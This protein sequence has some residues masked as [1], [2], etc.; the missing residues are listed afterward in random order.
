MEDQFEN[1]FNSNQKKALFRKIL[2]E[3]G[4][5]GILF[6]LAAGVFFLSSLN[7][8]TPLLM[9]SFLLFH[10]F[11]C[12][13]TRFNEH[14]AHP[15]WHFNRGNQGLLIFSIGLVSLGY[16]ITYFL[17]NGSGTVLDAN[18]RANLVVKYSYV[19]V[20]WAI[21]ASIS[22]LGIYFVVSSVVLWFPFLVRM[23]SS[24]NTPFMLYINVIVVAFLSLGVWI[25]QCVFLYK[26]IFNREDHGPNN[27]KFHQ[28]GIL[29]GNLG[30]LISV[31]LIILEN[32]LWSFIESWL[33]HV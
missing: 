26:S 15:I 4:N 22:P 6:M 12:G 8:L 1:Y 19:M 23:I 29:L 9:L 5:Y 3:W 13:L 10:F 25:T 7:R 31:C 27:Q 21:V 11:I 24:I 30:S 33:I 16:F 17:D 14:E 32:F 18:I 28:Y 20:L 2:P